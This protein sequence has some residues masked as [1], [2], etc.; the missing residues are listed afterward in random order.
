MINGLKEGKQRWEEHLDNTIR[1]ENN[2]MFGKQ[3]SEE[4]ILRN[5]ANQPYL[6]K[7]LPEWLRKK[8]SEGTK[9]EKNPFY[10]KTHTE[11][12]RRKI[13]ESRKK[14]YK[15]IYCGH[16]SNK[17]VITKYHNEKCKNKWINNKNTND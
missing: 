14:R 11:E 7:S 3:H 8:I 1:G 10:G 17:T 4:S 12:T 2:P 15:C 16:E 5:I 6:G 13:S 9:G